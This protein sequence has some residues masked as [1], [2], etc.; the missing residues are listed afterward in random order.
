MSR[1][2]LRRATAVATLAVTAVVAI[3]ACKG[4]PGRMDSD[5]KS[6]S[7]VSV[8]NF[9]QIAPEGLV[10]EIL[11]PGASGSLEL[12]GQNFIHNKEMGPGKLDCLV[13][14]LDWNIPELKV[15]FD[16]F[17]NLTPQKLA[18]QKNLEQSLARHSDTISSVN[19][20]SGHGKISRLTGGFFIGPCGDSEL[21]L[22]TFTTISMS[23]APA[24][25]WIELV[26]AMVDKI[27]KPGI[28]G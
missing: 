26:R 3:G 14:G 23:L 19:F 15:T 25:I 20:S 5:I 24:V 16:L 9:C 12:R 27:S 13:R 21:Y 4:N 28:C 11:N 18:S 10:R 6:A 7:T 2:R 8:N 1:L 22:L 17:K